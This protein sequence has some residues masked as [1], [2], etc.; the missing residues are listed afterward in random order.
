M[1]YRRVRSQP[2]VVQIIWT[3][4]CLAFVV[5]LATARWSLAFVSLSTFGLSLLPVLFQSRFG[6]QLPVRFFAGIVIFVFATIFLGEAFDFYNR[7]WWWDVALHGGSA[8]GFGLIGFLFVF[9]LFEGDRYAAPAWAVAFVSFCFALSIGA[10][11][12]IFE[13]AMDQA[14]GLNMQKTGLV[15]TMWDLIVDT[16]GAG[17]GAFVGFLYLKG[18]EVGGLTSVLQEFVQKN[19]QFFRKF[20]R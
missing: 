14:F 2:I 13:F 17:F 3:V 6:I 15:D 20:R 1:W 16:V 5:A 8:L 19:R 12:E 9:M 11:W 7:F 4:L 18:Q 10:M